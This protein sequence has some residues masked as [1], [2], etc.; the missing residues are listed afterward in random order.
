MKQI[1][2][3]PLRVPLWLLQEKGPGY[4]EWMGSCAKSITEE[5]GIRHEWRLEPW[6]E[7]YRLE[8]QMGDS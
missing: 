5:T 2:K 6:S 8:P 1:E 3:P 7:Y 4:A